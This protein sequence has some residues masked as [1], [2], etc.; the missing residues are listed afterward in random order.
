MYRKKSLLA[1]NYYTVLYSFTTV[2]WAD[3]PIIE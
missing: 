1:E 3:F 2:D